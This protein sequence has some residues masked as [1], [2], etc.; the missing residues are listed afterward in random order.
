MRNPTVLHSMF[1]LAAWTLVVL[2]F[3]AGAHLGAAP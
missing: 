3:A 1:A 2:R